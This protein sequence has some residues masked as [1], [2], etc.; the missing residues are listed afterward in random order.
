[1]ISLWRRSFVVSFVSSFVRYGLLYLCRS[2]FL[3]VCI[4]FVIYFVRSPVLYVSVIA[5]VCMVLCIDVCLY[6]FVVFLYIVLSF[7]RSFVLY[8]LSSL[9]GCVFIALAMYDVLLSVAS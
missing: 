9:F 5:Y 4:A 2:F 1:V 3:Y 8:A 7:V 6:V